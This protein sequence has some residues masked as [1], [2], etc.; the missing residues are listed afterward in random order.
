M[1]L[2]AARAAVSAQWPEVKAD[3]IVV[4]TAGWECVAFDIQDR[5]IAKFPRH[6]S[7]LAALEREV[8]LLAAV[9]L[10]VT[11]PVPDLQLFAGP[12]R[13]SSHAK[14]PGTH[15]LT[16]QYDTLPT[17]A[18]DRLAADLARFL[19]ETHAL[20]PDKMRRLGAIDLSP[21]P[22]GS[23]IADG[24][25]PLLPA[26]LQP[27]ARDVL[28]RWD[29]LPPDPLGKVFGQFDGHGWNMAFDHGAGRLNGIY[30]FGDAGIGPCHRDFVYSSLISVDLTL[31]IL[32]FY[33]GL[34]GNAPDPSRIDILIGTHRLWELSGAVDTPDTIPAMI[35]NVTTW[36]QTRF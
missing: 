36:A 12:P 17:P 20:N 33:A 28:N 1:D 11:L 10:A 3:Q 26:D 25:M 35:S 16:A 27:L 13:F 6:A 32:P 22:N 9:R 29:N 19:A 4:L 31:R 7:A 5:T 30:D 2:T 18:R 8:A 15:L 24:A 21:W 34:T 23:Q 14:L